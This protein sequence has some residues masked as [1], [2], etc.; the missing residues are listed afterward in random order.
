MMQHAGLGD[1][2]RRVCAGMAEWQVDCRSR[3]R[4]NASPAA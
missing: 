1:E 2:V 4:T 3:S